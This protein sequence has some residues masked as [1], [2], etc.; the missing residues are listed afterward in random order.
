LKE[1]KK[2]RGVVNNLLNPPFTPFYKVSLPLA[3]SMTDRSRMAL[4]GETAKAAMQA[5][6]TS[7]RIS[8]LRAYESILPVD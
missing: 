2:E 6:A 5:E 7:D 8:F 3:Y 1:A 4:V